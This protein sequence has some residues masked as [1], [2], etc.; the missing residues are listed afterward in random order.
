MKE[1]NDISANQKVAVTSVS[2]SIA[3]LTESLQY[4]L[5][6]LKQEASFIHSIRQQNESVVQMIEEISA[7]SQQTAAASEEIA[8]SMEE[9][10]T[11]ANELAQYTEKLFMLTEEL[12]KEIGEFVVKR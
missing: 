3:D 12:D 11:S 7:V 10:A 5:D 6:L 1:T 8:S 9:Q 2:A 4:M